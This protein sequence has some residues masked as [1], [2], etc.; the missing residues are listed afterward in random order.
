MW[1]RAAITLDRAQADEVYDR[2]RSNYGSSTPK[3]SGY[4]FA[5]VFER[6]RQM[7]HSALRCRKGLMLD[8]ACGSGLMSS[9]LLTSPV[10]IVGLDFNHGACAAARH[11]GLMSVRGD[12]FS[13]PF[14]EGTFD[15]IL[16]AEF[17]Q[18]YSAES[19]AG[20]FPEIGRVMKSDGR[21]VVVWRNGE[22]ILRRLSGMAFATYD[23]LSRRPPLAMIDHDLPS[24][25][26][27]IQSAGF[28]AIDQ[29]AIVPITKTWISN[30]D[31]PMARIIGTNFLVVLKK[32]DD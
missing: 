28:E 3:S 21:V 4:R 8:L 13:L 20:I 2:L 15:L 24:V 12:A 23:R 11:N 1:P 10:E 6:E 18:Q 14:R 32:A 25:R 26:T 31:S 22:S 30:T 17:L 7:I 27:M 9:H 16:N 5:F 19:A 29:F